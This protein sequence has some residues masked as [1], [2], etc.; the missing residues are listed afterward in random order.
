MTNDRI[1]NMAQ[2]HSIATQKKHLG[3]VCKVGN[4]C[5]RRF[6]PP[7]KPDQTGNVLGSRSRLL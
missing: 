3:A 1:G 7:S 4:D 5:F 2:D 6:S